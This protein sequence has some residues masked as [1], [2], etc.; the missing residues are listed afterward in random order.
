[1]IQPLINAFNWILLFVSALPLSVQLF[2]ALTFSVFAVT[3]VVNI[4]QNAR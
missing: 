1:M 2:L 4:V 3:A